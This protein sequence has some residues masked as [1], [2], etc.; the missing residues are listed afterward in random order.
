MPLRERQPARLTPSAAEARLARESGP[1]VA[2]VAGRKRKSVRIQV[3]DNGNKESI[4]LPMSAVRA[5]A[6]V[7]RQMAQGNAVT[8]LS[9]EAELTTQQAAGL[10][11]VSRPF[12]VRLLDEGQIPSR[13][14]GTHRRVRSR[15]VLAWKQRTDRARLR[16][17]AELQAQAQELD[18]GY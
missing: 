15:D 11:N 9:S 12:L 5:L 6:D 2:K 10:L 17:L 7:L 13:K 16:A 8:L 14:V 1:R 18:M 4:E 3:E